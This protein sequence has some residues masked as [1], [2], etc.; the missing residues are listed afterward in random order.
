MENVVKSF[1]GI[2]FLAL[3]LLVASRLIAIQL[4]VQNAREC[5][6]ELIDQIENS[7]FN[8]QVINSCI[9]QAKAQGYEVEIRLYRPEQTVEVLTKGMQVSE[10]RDVSM[11]KITLI[12]P[13][14]MWL[15]QNVRYRNVYGFAR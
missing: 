9:A 3:L 12:Y 2:F 8:A 13:Y 6:K 1:L 5:H 11:A 10:T 4:Q 15:W 7:H 14:Q